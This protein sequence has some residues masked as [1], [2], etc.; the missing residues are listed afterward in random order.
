MSQSQDNIFI[1][2]KTTKGKPCIGYLGE[3]YRF[4]YESK[5]TGYKSWICCENESSGCLA[6]KKTF[7]NTIIK[8]PTTHFGHQIGNEY[9]IRAA[10]I[11][12]SIKESATNSRSAPST[13]VNTETR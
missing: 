1:E 6:T 8:Q 3:K 9:T 10:V 11:S 5:I 4:K 12:S 7:E 2:F 13:I